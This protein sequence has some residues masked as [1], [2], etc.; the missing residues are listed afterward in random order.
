MQVGTIMYS[1]SGDSV[2]K[3]FVPI[4]PFIY[5]DLRN[6]SSFSFGELYIPSPPLRLIPLP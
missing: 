3:A 4:F 1:Q 6:G 5:D 2:Q